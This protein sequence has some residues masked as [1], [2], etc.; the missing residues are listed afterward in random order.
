MG[1]EFKPRWKRALK[2]YC[3]ESESSLKQD[4]PRHFPQGYAG[5]AGRWD[6]L[7]VLPT[8]CGFVFI[9]LLFQHIRFCVNN[10]DVF[11]SSVQ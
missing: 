5:Q 4:H 9:V 11:G 10:K 1:E 8:S 2:G 7:S 3:K 6:N